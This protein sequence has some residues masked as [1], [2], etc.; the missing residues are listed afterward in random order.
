MA[1][2]RGMEKQRYQNAGLKKATGTNQQGM[3]TSEWKRRDFI[4]MTAKPH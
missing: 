4:S 3:E 1:S 2:K